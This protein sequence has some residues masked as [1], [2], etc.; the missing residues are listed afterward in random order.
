MTLTL[1]ARFEQIEERFRYVEERFKN[2][3][4]L[5]KTEGA[6]T[7]RH[8]DVVA[9]GLRDQIKVVAEGYV[10]LRTDVIDFFPD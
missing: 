3:E 6:A 9:E 8:F 4:D 5:V 1:N 2:V 7:R 10:V